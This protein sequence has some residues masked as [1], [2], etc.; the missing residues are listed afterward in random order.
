[1]APGKRRQLGKTLQVEKTVSTK[2]LER[3]MA[4]PV[5]REVRAKSWKAL[6]AR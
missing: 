1:M 3:G 5:G 4:E 6:N 2:A